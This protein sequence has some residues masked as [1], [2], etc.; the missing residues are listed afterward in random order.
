MPPRPPEPMRADSLDPSF[1]LI[2]IG[3]GP[4]GQRAAVQAAKLGKRVALIERGSALGG[5]STNT[6]TVPSKTLR[7]AIVELTGRAASVYGNAFRVKH[8]ITIDD[9]LWRTHQVIEH[10]QEVI[11]DQLRRNG[12]R[13]FEGTASFVDPHTLE[14]AGDGASFRLTRRADR[15]R[16]RHDARAAGRRRVRRAHRARLRR[17]PPPGRAAAH[18]DRDRRRRDRA[19]VRLDGRRA[20]RPRHARR[21]AAADPRLRRRRARRGAPV[22]PARPRARVPP[23]RGGRGGAPARR[24]RRGHAPRERQGAAVGRRRLR[25]RPPGRDRRARTSP[26]RASRPTRAAGSRSATTT[27]P[28]SRTS[29]RPAT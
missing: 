22:P 10:E 20:R 28:R 3:S 4:A 27:A 8:E 12:V 9:L 6:G 29:S 5:V 25:R 24:R 21:E 2:A 16:R 1:D 15:D 13:V 14:V 23:R 7:A 26:P 19:R 11:A 17:D 18:A